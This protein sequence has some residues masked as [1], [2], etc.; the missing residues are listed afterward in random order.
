MSSSAKPVL[1]DD[2]DYAIR[3]ERSIQGTTLGIMVYLRDIWEPVVSLFNQ[4]HREKVSIRYAQTLE[5]LASFAIN[6]EADFIL[7]HTNP[8]LS[9]VIPDTQAFVSM[10]ALCSSIERERYYPSAFLNDPFGRLWGIAPTIIIPTLFYNPRYAE[11]P[12]KNLSWDEFF[13][14]LD[15]VA[16]NHPELKYVFFFDGYMNYLFNCGV[17]MVNPKTKKVEFNIVSF[18]KPLLD[19]KRIT[20]KNRAPLVSESFYAGYGRSMFLEEKIA[21]CQ[22]SYSNGRTFQQILPSCVPHPFPSAANCMPSTAAEFFSICMHS[23]NY[24][25]AWMF[26]KFSLSP[27]IQQ[28]IP[29]AGH[30]MPS[31]RD[32][33]PEGMDA[34]RF[35]LFEEYIGRTGSKPEDYLFP[36]GARL[37]LEAGIDRWL[38]FGGNMREML[39]DLEKSC[40]QNINF[41]QKQGNQK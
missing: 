6:A 8:V 15:D 26:I 3:H 38:R 21:V 35:K 16:R 7:F 33:R 37:I 13:H 24:E 36:L 18:E 1:P 30:S 29:H 28:K 17:K 10:T 31:L 2:A 34:G 9:E 5:E 23:L 39:C 11:L 4:T 19:L 12:E 25:T 32:L 22:R 20:G 40:S 27:E 14:S 41:N